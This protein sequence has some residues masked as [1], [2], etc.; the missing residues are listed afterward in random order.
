MN[1]Y[2]DYCGICGCTDIKTTSI[3]EWQKMYNERFSTK[4]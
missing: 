4:L 2:I 3:E 1:D